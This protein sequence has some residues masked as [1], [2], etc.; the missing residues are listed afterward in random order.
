MRPC[1]VQVGSGDQRISWREADAG[2]KRGEK[3]VFFE[4]RIYVDCTKMTES[5]R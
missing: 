1:N 4:S 2:E 5:N 3:Y